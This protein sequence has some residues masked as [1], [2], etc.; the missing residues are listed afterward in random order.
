MMKTP[1]QVLLE[2]HRQAEPA[3]DEIRRKV[4]NEAVA[5]VGPKRIAGTRSWVGWLRDELLRPYHVAWSGLAAAWLL[6]AGL[7]LARA[8]WR[9]DVPASSL[10]AVASVR[11]ILIEQ[12]TLRAE[13]LDLG[14]AALSGAEAADEGQ[15]PG[16]RSE[17][18]RAV[19]RIG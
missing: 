2:H 6:I 4:L 16:P 5:R 18:P 1:G 15:L 8:P 14:P 12:A 17:R 9:E 7:N 13:L 11:E 19:D 10:P 3:L